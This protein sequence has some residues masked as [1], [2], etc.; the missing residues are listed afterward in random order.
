MF[1]NYWYETVSSFLIKNLEF[2]AFISRF[3]NVE[4]S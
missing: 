1:Y 3:F 2:Y 4:F